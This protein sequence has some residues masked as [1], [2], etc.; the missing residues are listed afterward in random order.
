M[1][2]WCPLWHVTKT[3]REKIDPKKTYVVV[4]NHQSQLD[5]LVAFGLFFHYKWVSKIEIFK[6]P[7][8]GWN[9][10]LNDYIKLV[11]GDKDSVRRMLDHC[12]R[13]LGQGNSVWIFPE[14]SRSKDGNLRDFKHGAFILAKELNLPI[15]PIAVS[16]TC[17]APCPK[18]AWSCAGIGISP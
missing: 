6:L 4:S 16:G 3:G 2:G 1:S 12:R 9:M 10:I 5:I 14:G 11:R 17:H 7:F 18:R 8:I 13:S 15:L